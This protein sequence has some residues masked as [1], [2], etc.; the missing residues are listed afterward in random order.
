MA[1]PGPIADMEVSGHTKGWLTS[2]DGWGLLGAKP[3]PECAMSTLKPSSE[4]EHKIAPQMAVVA[5]ARAPAAADHKGQVEAIRAQDEGLVAGQLGTIFY[6]PVTV[7]GIDLKLEPV[8]PS[9]GTIV[10]GIDLAKDIDNPDVVS[11]LRELWLERRVIM[12]REQGHLTRQEMVNFA[13]KFGEIGAHHGERDHVPDLPTSVPGFPDMLIIA[14]GEKRAGAA[15]G[16]HSDATWSTRPPMGSV[17]ICREAPPVGGDTSF[18]CAYSMWNGLSDAT[19]AK[20]EHLQAVHVGSPHHAMDGK[21]PRAVHPVPRTHPET[22]RTTLFIPRSF[23]KQFVEGPGPE[24]HGLDDDEAKS[25]LAELYD[26]AGQPEYT[27][28]FRWE[29]GSLAMWD[30]RAV[31]HR[32]TADFWPHRRSMERLTILDYDQKRRAPYYDPE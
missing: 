10:H 5:S 16:W 3:N 30:N 23:V 14:S 11:F 19:R 22:G 17:L 12:F 29:A 25:L 1:A 8:Q 13:E 15:S 32:A 20:I 24:G 2:P 21:R 7:C 27:C 31:Q 28:R 4:T 18:C 9:I 26:Q 6:K